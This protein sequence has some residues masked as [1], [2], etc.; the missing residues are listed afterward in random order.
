MS[1]FSCFF[2]YLGL[3]TYKIYFIIKCHVSLILPE[4]RDQIHFVRFTSSLLLELHD[5]FLY[6]DVYWTKFISSVHL[7]PL[8]LAIHGHHF[9]G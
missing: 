6:V 9:L 7:L 3:Y 2:H 8:L 1:L 5:Y 4:I